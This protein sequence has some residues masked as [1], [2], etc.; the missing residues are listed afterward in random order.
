MGAGNTN[1]KVQLSRT[2]SQKITGCQLWS[3]QCMAHVYA[4]H[5]MQARTYE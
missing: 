4:R 2:K 3:Q 5:Y 1:A